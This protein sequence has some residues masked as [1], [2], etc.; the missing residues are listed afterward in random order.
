MIARR[1]T[2]QLAIGRRLDFE[3]SVA[4]Q[5]ARAWIIATDIRF[6]I[7][8]ATAIDG[9][10]HVHALAEAPIAFDDGIGSIDAVNNHGH[11]GAAR[12]HNDRTAVGQSR[13]GGSDQDSQCQYV[14][15]SSGFR[16]VAAT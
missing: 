16:F 5:T 3:A 2:R 9:G 6:D 13:A 12:N 7:D 1:G 4:R 10:L 8:D 15:H 11:P 14:T